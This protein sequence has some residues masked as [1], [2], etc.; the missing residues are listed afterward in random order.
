M[1]AEPHEEAGRALP[2]LRS[3]QLGRLRRE[4]H[5]ERAGSRGGEGAVGVQSG[6]RVGTGPAGCN[7]TF[8]S[9][10]SYQA[11]LPSPL[12]Q[13]PLRNTGHS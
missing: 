9:Q 7:C 5:R 8:P 4:H 12:E 6:V 10:D 1:R 13:S 3:P 2:Q 11:I